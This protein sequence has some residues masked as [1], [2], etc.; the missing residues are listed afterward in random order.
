MLGRTD[1]TADVGVDRHRHRDRHRDRR[2]HIERGVVILA[3]RNLNEGQDPWVRGR[4]KVL[5]SRRWRYSVE[6]IIADGGTGSYSIYCSVDHIV[7][8]WTVDNSI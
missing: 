5:I 4:E 7:G 2:S 3:D 6:K 8:S 1:T